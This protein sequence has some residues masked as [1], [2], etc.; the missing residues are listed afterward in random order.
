MALMYF[1]KRDFA[2]TGKKND[3]S[4]FQQVSLVSFL[5]FP[6]KE[7]KN[8]HVQPFLKCTTLVVRIFEIKINPK[9]QPMVYL[10][11]FIQMLY[12]KIEPGLKTQVRRIL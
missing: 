1:Y 11:I 12:C 2:M 3:R 8:F 6:G 4:D 9:I 5:F 10:Q 7:K